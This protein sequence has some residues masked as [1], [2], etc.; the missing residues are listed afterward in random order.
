VPTS[1]ENAL[2]SKLEDARARLSA[3]QTTA[4]CSAMKAFVNA[5]NDKLKG[6]SITPAQATQ[7]LTAANRIRAVLGCS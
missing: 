7:L 5:V 6:K 1:T 2:V 3:G 4:T